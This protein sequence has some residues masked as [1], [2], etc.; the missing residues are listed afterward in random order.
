ML[1]SRDLDDVRHE[2]AVIIISDISRGRLSAPNDI[3]FA[4]CAIA[5]L[6]FTQ[7]KAE[8]RYLKMIKAE[9]QQEAFINNIIKVKD[10]EHSFTSLK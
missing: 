8:D 3:W 7:L 9:Y 1:V 5:Y 2:P 6:F 4:I 10:S